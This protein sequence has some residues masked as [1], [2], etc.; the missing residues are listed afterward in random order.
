MPAKVNGDG[1]RGVSNCLFFFFFS[2]RLSG[3]ASVF[4]VFFSHVTSD[5]AF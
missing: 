2:V 3:A 5:L 4:Y 1:D